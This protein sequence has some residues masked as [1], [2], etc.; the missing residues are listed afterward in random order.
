MKAS[1]PVLVPQRRLTAF[2]LLLSLGLFA[3]P[4]GSTG[5][6]GTFFNPDDPGGSGGD[7][8]GDGGGTTP[9]LGA[10]EALL[11]GARVLS[12]APTFVDSAPADA[13][14]GVDVR[15]PI[16]LWFSESLNSSSVNT[17]SLILRPVDSPLTPVTT[18]STWLSG[19]RL[20]V[21][22]PTLSLAP[23]TRYEVVAT[24]DIVDL[25]G[26]RLRLSANGLLLRF[27]TSTLSTGLAP[28]VLGSFP[29]DGSTEEPNDQPVF[30]VFSEPMD[31]T[32]LTDAVTLSNLTT[33]VDADFDTAGEASNRHAGNRVFGFPHVSDALDLGA[34]LRLAIDT[35]ITDAE[36]VPQSLSASYQADW[37]SLA[38]GRPSS[39]QFDDADFTPFEPAANLG[40]FDLFPV[41]VVVPVSV[42]SSDSVHLWAHEDSTSDYVQES[43]LAGGGVA[44][45]TLDLGEGSG[46]SV[47]GSRSEL[48]L[49]A[50]VE[51]A[52]KR[53]NV[54]TFRDE[55]G[56]EDTVPHDMVRPVLYSYGPPSGTFGSQ[57]VVDTPHFRPYG[58]ASEPIRRVTA[59]HP[60]T[61][62][63]QTRDVETPS[64][65]NAFI[66]PA[67]DPL[68]ITEG[69]LAFDITLTDEAGNAASIASPGQVEFRG[70]LS[71]EAN[72]SGEVRVVAFDQVSLQPISGA[73]VYV[74]DFGAGNEDSATTGSDGSWTF[75]GRSGDQSF[76]IIADGY[77]AVSVMGVDVAELSAPLVQKGRSAASLTPAVTGLNTGTL[78]IPFSTSATAAG[79]FDP[80]GIQSYDLEDLF[81]LGLQARHDRPAWFAAFHDVVAYPASDRYYRFFAA[82]ERLLADPSTTSVPVPPRFTMVESTN[83]VASSTDYIYPIQ[84]S[85]GVGLSL[86]PVS[87]SASLV[88]TIPGLLGTC[89]VGAGSVDFSGGGTN[90]AVEM[91]LS[92]MSAAVAEG[93]TS[94]LASLQVYAKDSDGDEAMARVEVTVTA[95]PSATPIA[96]PDIPSV[97]AAWSG[98]SYP[99]TRS[100]TDTL[101]TS[102][103]FYRLTVEDSSLDA[104]QWHL[105]FSASAGSGGSLELPTLKASAAGAVG[106]PPL[107]TT[108]GGHWV[109]HLEAMEMAAGFHERGFFFTEL[110]RDAESWAS[111]AD[112]PTLDF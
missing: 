108:A 30:A 71:T 85:G 82:D 8:S 95:S 44:A 86:P 78:T 19:Q 81:A 39:V 47:F 9:G 50:F 22:V 90:G 109:A 33:A 111:S 99:Y 24:D 97:S 59:T 48:V 54:Q 7:G 101:T 13:S 58:R 112:S 70:F 75:T 27:T 57:F 106:T 16:A 49:G 14:T 107:D 88:T 91:E 32:G 84:A 68:S 104:G 46:T 96:L 17:V 60:P 25:E 76:T 1:R 62:G 37:A 41:D 2:A 38:F 89:A 110:E 93:A 94:G 73:T 103:G 51:R 92:L 42:L 10:S 55:D 64:A 72:T 102:Q 77:H 3:G 100:F 21:L 83:Q 45:F 79:G 80:D 31:F 65:A 56:L 15:A 26:N 43:T 28:T 36:F 35:S 29:P 4:C 67:F 40:N 53:S 63:G 18:S 52:G 23:N 87:G 105:W 61:L 34:N 98:S 11:A 74:E 66:G 69:P 12:G 5:N 6:P 20:L